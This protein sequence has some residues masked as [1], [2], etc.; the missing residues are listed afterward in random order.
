LFP[1]GRERL[2]EHGKPIA[3]ELAVKLHVVDLFIDAAL[4]LDPLAECLEDDLPYSTVQG[5]FYI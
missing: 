4:E 2:A 5:Y 1:G 3:H